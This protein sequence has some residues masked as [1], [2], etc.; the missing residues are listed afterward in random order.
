M[1]RP[2]RTLERV[3]TGDGAL[4][5]RERG[6]RDYLILRDGRVLMTSTQ[7]RSEQALG[8]LACQ[9]LAGI[10]APRVLVAGL[11]MG[12]TLRAALD[13][14][15]PGAAVV[16]AELHE[17]VAR[18]VRG[19]LAALTANVLDDPRVTLAL[20]DVAQVIAR[21]S[22]APAP[23]FDA[24]VLDLFEGPRPGSGDPTDDH[25]FGAAALAR[26]SGALAPRGVLAVWSEGPVASFERRLRAAG[27]TVE[28]AHPAR[29]A[30][31]Y[32]VY[33]ARPAR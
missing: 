19:P 24:I 3:E 1:A 7:Q 11:G 33:L 10:A 12:Y 25:V 9:S 32:V 4:E 22:T 6:E 30:R 16:V 14:L 23:R 17:A 29:G 26:A 27:F 8:A 5:L 21:A 15:P 28:V 20:G 31:R 18:W 13:A 2:W